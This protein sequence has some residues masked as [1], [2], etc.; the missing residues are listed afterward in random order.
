MGQINVLDQALVNKIAA[1]EVIERP[2]SVV[3]E[4][5]E[6]SLDAKAE[7][8]T[9]EVKEGGKSHI[10]VSDDGKGMDKEDAIECFK[11]HATSKLANDDDLFKISTL[12]FRGEALSSIA[13]VSNVKL[14]TSQ[15]GE[16]ILVEVEAGDILKQEKIGTSKGTTIE[17]NEL[18][19]N[20]PAR[21]KYLK[22]REVELG[23]IIDIVTRYSFANKEVS[24]KL[25][26]D[27][28]E[29]LVSPKTNNLLNKIVNVYGKDIGKNMV[30][31]EFSDDFV[32]INGFIGK[33]YVTKMDR[34]YQTFFVNGRYVKNDKISKAI[35]DAYHTLLFLDRHPVVVL[36]FEIDFS[37]V[38]VNVH[39]T[40]NVIRIEKED[41]LYKGV[42]NAVRD[43]FVKNDLIPEVD[44]HEGTGIDV[45]QNYNIEKGQQVTLDVEN[46]TV[47]K[48][49]E[50]IESRVIGPTLILGQLNKMYILAE[51]A[52]GLL[53]VDQ[54]AAQERVKY[55]KFMK[56]FNSKQIE[57]QKLLSSLIIELGLNE[58]NFMLESIES[59]RNL[60]FDIEDYG[61]NSFIV[62][63]VPRLFK[64]FS[65][66]E[67]IEMVTEL[68][69]D[70]KITE[71]KEERIARMA[72]R[73]SVKA[74]KALSR[75][76]ME[77]II[78]DLDQAENPLSCPHGRPT[79]IN[80]SL[81]EL[82]KKFN[83]KA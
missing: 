4:L 21:K 50:I 3:K 38:D 18:F 46:A 47:V 59:F 11:R 53:I 16:G 15:G 29:T 81:G 82:E 12:G 48:Q 5:L 71:I 57:Q 70:K 42:F 52:K 65:K 58:T 67:I 9:I 25:I 19:F 54:H 45:K 34:N 74:G 83:R 60:G 68:S 43:T 6:N 27:G 23:H 78:V 66:K 28:R 61:N 41:E 44:A 49:P 55:E 36:S 63:Q 22:G 7:N 40:K 72:C 80:I 56:Q 33:P 1:G 2:Y 79:I 10:K 30:P 51:N 20:T 31:V 14:T 17:I 37:K 64:D 76:D 73:K 13:A 26:S 75:F 24:F 35:Y 62:R 39:P 77:K 69:A 8:I 32:K